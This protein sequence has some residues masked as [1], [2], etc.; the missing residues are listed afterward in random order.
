MPLLGINPLSSKMIMYTERTLSLATVANDWKQLKYPSTE[1]WINK[2]QYVYPMILII[3]LK[4]SPRC[5]EKMKTIQHNSVYS[6]FT[7]V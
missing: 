7:W 4:L 5:E 6:V 3:I 1:D 2:S